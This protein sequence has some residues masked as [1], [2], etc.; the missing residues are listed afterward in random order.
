MSRRRSP[1][2]VRQLN[3]K[4]YAVILVLAL[5]FIL[6]FIING[7]RNVEPPK[8]VRVDLTPV[9]T[10]TVAGEV[11]QPVLISPTTGEEIRAGLVAL[12][13]TGAPNAPLQVVL[14]GTVIGETTA[15]DQGNWQLDVEMLQAGEQELLIQGIEDGGVA[16]TPVVLVVA[17]PVAAAAEAV[18]E[19]ADAP[20]TTET[21]TASSEV[22]AEAEVASAVE[23]AEIEPAVAVEAPSIEEAA[24]AEVQAPGFVTLFGQGDAQTEVSISIDDVIAAVPGWRMMVPGSLWPV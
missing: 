4:K 7:L 14:N 22:K 1:D 18:D 8:E 19:E 13:G 9:P 11:V 2:E 5:I 21:T 6:I 15:D 10:Y 23:P 16:P 3:L 17:V 12:A 20:S 24:L